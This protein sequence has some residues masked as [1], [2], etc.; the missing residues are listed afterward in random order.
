MKHH[1]GL[2]QA[3][4]LFTNIQVCISPIRR[5]T[6]ARGIPVSAIPEKLSVRKCPLPSLPSFQ[7]HLPG[8]DS[9]SQVFND[10]VKAG[11]YFIADTPLDRAGV[12]HADGPD[13]RARIT[14]NAGTNLNEAKV[15]FLNFVP[16]E[17]AMRNARSTSKTDDRLYA[18]ELTP[19]PYAI[20]HRGSCDI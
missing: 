4:L 20:F 9:G 3:R 13:E 5:K 11:L 7:C 6:E 12:T 8:R 2:Q 16:A 1:S 19:L 15:S 14:V 18:K 10:R 17:G